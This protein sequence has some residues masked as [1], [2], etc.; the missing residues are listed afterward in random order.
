MKLKIDTRE[1]ALNV[2]IALLMDFRM[3]DFELRRYFMRLKTVRLKNF[4]GYKDAIDIPIS[5]LTT[6]IGRNDAGKSTILEALEIF[7]NNK[8]VKIDAGDLCIEA[9]EQEIEIS[10]VFDDLPE[11]IIV[12]TEVRTTFKEEYLLNKDKDLEIVKHYKITSS[13]PKESIFIRCLHPEGEDYGDLLSLKNSDLKKR[14]KN[15]DLNPDSYNASINKEIYSQIKTYLPTYALFQSDRPS[16]DDDPEVTDPMKIAVQA[17]LKLVDEELDKIKQQVQEAA[18]E[19]AERT[20]EKLKEM[21]PDI[22]KHLSSEFKSEPKFESLFKLT[23]KS[24]DNIPINKRGSGVRRLILLNFFRAEAE[25]RLEEEDKNQIIYAFEEPET[26]QHPKHQKMLLKAFQDLANSSA[27]QVIFTTHT[28]ALASA[29]PLDGLRFITSIDGVKTIKTS[30][31]ETLQEICDELGILPEAIPPH[32]KALIFVEGKD[33]ITFLKHLSKELSNAKYISEDLV[34]AK[35]GFIPISG[36]K[37]LKYWINHKL[38]EQFGLPWGILMDSDEGATH[39]TDNKNEI[40]KLKKDG[41][42]AF[43]TRK[44]EIENYIDVSVIEGYEGHKLTDTCDAK[45]EILSGLPSSDEKERKRKRSTFIDKFWTK[46]TVEQIRES[47]KYVDSNGET[48]YEFTEML[49]EF[50]TLVK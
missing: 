46:M 6:F 7:F 16:R 19:T 49:T 50:L 39:S 45:A 25:R 43:C 48:R 20:L 41:I 44:R 21:S 15:L 5:S 34:E 26:S 18:C 42:K 40:E 47:E 8:L 10:C 4:R 22:A 3:F 1:S 17:A 32:V 37:N 23:I 11:S 2:E 30:D 13:T 35:I 38:V 33:D 9:E 14:A 31:D 36:C 27:C 12:D 24:D 28:P 29:V